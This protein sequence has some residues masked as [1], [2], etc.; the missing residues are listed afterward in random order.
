MSQ[1]KD[2]PTKVTPKTQDD[3]PGKEHKM[4]T[5]PHWQNQEWKG[6]EKLKDN[7]ALIIGGDSGIGRAIS[8][9]YA[10]EGADIAI[11]YH[12]SEQKDAEVTKVAIEK[13]GRR[14]ILIP[15]DC[16]DRDFC[17]SC[18]KDCVDGLGKLDILVLHTGTQEENKAFETVT[19]ETIEETFKVNVYSHM[20]FVQAAIP[21]LKSGSS[22]II[23]SSVNAYRGHK[24]LV[25]YTATK[26]AN[27]SFIYA[28]AQ[29]LADKGIR[30]NGV[31]PGPI[32]TPL[33]SN[34]FDE[35]KQKTFGQDTL[36][37]RPGQPEEC[38]AS[39][40]FLACNQM[41]SYITGQM[42]H[43]NGGATLNT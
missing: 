27:R 11:N 13:E 20:Y 9:L 26:G 24:T 7:V 16:R 31:A 28:L 4:A 30:V 18:V 43:P 23:T 6:S 17:F 14:C 32:W 12:P 3:V 41:S 33:I 39:Y 35:E 34:S 29:Q 37:G 5:K 10:K 21:H 25:E 40:L 22:I 36:L 8:V 2:Y 42:L 1:Q 19:S 38:A 15:G